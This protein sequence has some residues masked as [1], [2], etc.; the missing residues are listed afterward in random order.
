M[1]TLNYNWQL[2]KETGFT[3]VGNNGL[4]LYGRLY[5][6][7]IN[8]NRSTVAFQLRV[9][10]YSGSFYS[11]QNTSNLWCA[12]VHRGTGPGEPHRGGGGELQPPG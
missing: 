6:Q 10:A 4:R 1:A 3:V 7:D 2:L 9:I 12:G 8:G 11:T 5:G